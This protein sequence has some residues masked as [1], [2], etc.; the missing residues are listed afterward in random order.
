MECNLYG[1]NDY[2]LIGDITK[3]TALLQHD[4]SFER[5]VSSIIDLSKILGV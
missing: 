3:E 1:I 4:S 2:L 5:R